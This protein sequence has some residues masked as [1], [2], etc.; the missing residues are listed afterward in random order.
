MLPLIRR[1][2]PLVLGTALLVIV[3]LYL[4]MAAYSAQRGQRQHPPAPPCAAPRAEQPATAADDGFF[5]NCPPRTGEIRDDLQPPPEDPVGLLNWVVA[6]NNRPTVLNE[7]VFG[8]LEKV[9]PTRIIVIQ[10]HQRP[11]YLRWLLHSLSRVRGIESA[12]LVLSHSHIDADL[13]AAARE[14]C[15]CRAVRI[16]F[17]YS[18]QIWPDQFPGDECGSQTNRTKCPREAKVTMAKHHW[19][20]LHNFV[21]NEIFAL[22]KYNATIDGREALALFVE[23][24]TYLSPDALSVLDMMQRTRPQADI[25][26]LNDNNGR[27]GQKSSAR[28]LLT[29]WVYTWGVAMGL[30]TWAKIARCAKMF[31]SYND[32]NYD[33]SVQALG[34]RC[35]PGQLITLVMQD[36]RLFHIGKCGGMHFKDATDCESLVRTVLADLERAAKSGAL[37]PS[38]LIVSENMART[39]VSQ[40]FGGWTDP[41][42]H[43][44]CLDNANASLTRWPSDA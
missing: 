27:L 16:F 38:K 18:M 26:V 14:V 6:A 9:T 29:H 8:T 28:A 31:C 24:D 42:D 23:E 37:F 41:R 1:C 40:A 35:V 11:Q 39:F 21:F 19:W 2:R 44:L 12:L 3:V 10:V 25:L 5:R 34:A 33:W 32:Y 30:R 13:V 4:E 7:D 17:P 20:W 43:Q 22:A 36:S 15:F